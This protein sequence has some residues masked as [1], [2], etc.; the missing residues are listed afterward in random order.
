MVSATCLCLGLISF[1]LGH[2]SSASFPLDV[3]FWGEGLFS[4]LK[5]PWS[6]ICGLHWVEIENRGDN[7]QPLKNIQ[8][9][10]RARHSLPEF[11][12][13]EHFQMEQ[14]GMER[15]SLTTGKPRKPREAFES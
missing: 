5:R 11:L 2:R 9:N 8:G 14:E 12:R 13:A 1:S 7:I 4:S 3:T 6:S 15:S 10:E